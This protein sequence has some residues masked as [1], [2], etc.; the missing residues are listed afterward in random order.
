M[1]EYKIKCKIDPKE[2]AELRKSVG[3]NG[4]LDSYRKSL[5]KS[6]FYL[7][8]FNNNEL[9]VFLDV[10]SNGITDAYIQDVI[11][12]PSFQKKG[13][14]KELMKIA[15]EKLTQDGVYVI[16]VLFTED[17]MNFYKKFGFNIMMAG[18]METRK[19][20]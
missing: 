5:S 15:I 17:N 12:K 11:V 3:W 14:G 10:V 6:Y 20:E 1:F 2:I 19:E 16:S 13:I 4:M 8:C 18:Q 9:I 7:C